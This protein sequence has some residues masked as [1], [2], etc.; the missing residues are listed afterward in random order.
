[1][2]KTTRKLPFKAET[3]KRLVDASLA[4]AAGGRP[5]APTTSDQQTCSCGQG[6]CNETGD[7]GT[8]VGCGP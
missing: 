4:A 1:M 2:K 7:C 8:V 6:V 3:V 5:F